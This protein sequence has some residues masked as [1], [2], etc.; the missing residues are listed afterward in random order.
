ML[1]T[2]R[3]GS[4]WLQLKPKKGYCMKLEDLLGAELYSQV[5]A[6]ID[7]KDAKRVDKCKG[8]QMTLI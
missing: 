7:E 2:G 5:Q 6:K 8:V 1:R 3:Y 4:V